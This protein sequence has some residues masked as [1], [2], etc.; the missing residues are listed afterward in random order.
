MTLPAKKDELQPMELATLIA[1]T[2]PRSDAFGKKGAA[3]KAGGY[4][5]GRAGSHPDFWKRPRVRKYLDD[6]RNRITAEADVFAEELKALVPEVVGELRRQVLAG[7][8]FEF[9][10]P[11]EVFGKILKERGHFSMADG[12]HLDGINKHNANRLRAMEQARK[13]A[14]KVLD[15]AVGTPEQRM[16]VSHEKTTPDVVDLDKLGFEEVEILRNAAGVALERKEARGETAERVI[17]VDAVEVVE[18]DD[19]GLLP[20]DL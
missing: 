7:T 1:Y 2:D 3:L 15:Y 17:E 11:E 20:L 14:E 18:E 9:I 13:A 10:D 4:S 6:W 8:E 19:D 12:K 5:R 16:K